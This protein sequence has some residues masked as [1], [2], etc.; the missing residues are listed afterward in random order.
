MARLQFA[1]VSTLSK[2]ASHARHRRRARG[3]AP[4]AAVVLMALAFPAAAIDSYVNFET[5]PTRPVALSPDGSRLFVVNTPGAR[6]EVFDVFKKRLFHRGSVPVGIDPVSVAARS[7]DEVWVVNH[8]SDS[9]SIVDVSAWPAR[10]VRTLLVGD[11]PWDV[12]FAGT[13]AEPGGPFPRAFI[14]AARRG[15]NHREDA[16]LD[17]KREGVGRADVWVF[18]ADALGTDLGG[19]PE[20]IVRL[21]GDKPRALTVSADGSVVYVGVFHSGNQTAT[22][23]S[24]AVC[25]GGADRGQCVLFNAFDP[26]APSIPGEPGTGLIPIL[27]GGLP[28]PNNDSAGNPGPETGLIVKFD[29]ESN[30]WRDELGRNWNGAV[31]FS[32]PDLDVFAID[33]TAPEPVQI[34]SFAGV[35]TVLFAMAAHPNGR[36]YVTNTEAKNE[37]RFEGPG[38]SS[39][40]VR[41]RLHEARISVLHPDGQVTP[42]HLNKHIDYAQMPTPPGVRDHSLAT[43]QQLAFSRNGRTLYVAAFGSSKIGVF[44]TSQIDD[45]SFVPDSSDHIVL[46]G[47]GPSGFAIDDARRRLY[48]YNRFD[49]TLSVVNLRR[50]R[51]VAVY[52]LPNPEPLPV[53]TGR[54][55][56]YDADFTSSNGEASC[57]SCHISGDK[58]D[59][60]WDLGNPDGAIIPNLNPLVVSPPL[61]D[62]HPMKGP[63]TTQTLRGMANHGPMHW[64]GDRSAANN[65]T[66]FNPF[67]EIAAFIAFNGAFD[68]LLGRDEG[69]LDDADMRAFANFALKILPPPS[70]IRPLNDID[71]PN[72]F[73]GRVTYTTVPAALRGTC[74]RCHTLD[75]SQ[76]FF[77]TSGFS[78]DDPGAF[79]IPKLFNIYDKVGAFGTTLQNPRGNSV[80]PLGP[81]IRGFGTSHDGSTGSVQ[82]FLDV[83]GFSQR[84]RDRGRDP[85]Q[86]TDFLLAFPSVLAPV[87][88]QQITRGADSPASVDT[89]I[90][91]LIQQASRPFVLKHEPS[92]KACELI[93][94]AVVG[95]MTRGWLYDPD[96]AVFL[97]DR[98]GDPELTDAQMRS[99]SDTPG[100]AVTFT[101]VP[102]ES[103]ER[104]GVDFDEDRQL[105]ADAFDN[106][107]F[108]CRTARNRR[109]HKGWRWVGLSDRFGSAGYVASPTRRLCAPAE[110]DRVIEDR[111]SVELTCRNLYGWFKPAGTPLR[112]DNAFGDDQGLLVGTARQLCVPAQVDP[113]VAPAA[114]SSRNSLVCYD[115]ASDADFDAFGLTL[116][117]RYGERNTRAVAP[118][119]FCT[120][121]VA[122]DSTAASRDELVCY[123]VRE[124]RRGRGPEKHARS[125]VRASD[126]LDDKQRLEIG[127]GRSVC[128]PSATRNTGGS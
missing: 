58:D 123:S 73:E 18:D 85:E 20:T 95:G 119:S 63:M 64:R 16:N 35:G 6:L 83:S 45:D 106:H 1:G 49:N 15:Q 117:D 90:D 4:F 9:V 112:V 26:N 93:A 8:L 120:P 66:V 102:P 13:P 128:I 55:F 40:T 59:L 36:V 126:A 57:S 31:P 86:I 32:V 77:G 111:A 70:P 78:T 71:P 115:A 61:P 74:N 75:P 54:P 24:A 30:Q 101:C 118:E 114:A 82:N 34:Q 76:G 2:C 21:F 110:L 41:G 14:S 80:F 89:R 81:Q 29:S 48:A 103:G 23:N 92:A 10:V 98:D 46:S 94:K 5:A 116:G 79:K 7:D 43:P 11:E 67:D 39:T 105:D 108:Q 122:S 97:P 65:P 121:V 113:P 125:Q 38:T 88:G 17:L 51:E 19:T 127:A 69:P 22:V 96:L 25:N 109:W 87:V 91:L 42:R 27:P 28:A 100:Q 62:F 33:A 56:L 84:F 37:V 52:T 12:A 44:E 50:R 3:I 53:R 104:S 124:E 99:L 72:V 68:G 47:G 107:P 60:A